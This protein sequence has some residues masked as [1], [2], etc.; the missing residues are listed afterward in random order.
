M[1]FSIQDLLYRKCVCEYAYLIYF[2]E[3]TDFH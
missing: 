1:H 3:Y 2:T